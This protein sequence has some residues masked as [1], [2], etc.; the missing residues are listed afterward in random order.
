M[1]LVWISLAVV[2]VT[3]SGCTQVAR[4]GKV[5]SKGAVVMPFDLEQT[6]HMFEK[7]DNG[8]LQQVIADKPDDTEQIT[9]IRQHLSE[10]A[11]RFALGD[12]HDPGMIH[13]EGMPGLH[14]LMTGA[15][16]IHIEYSEIPDG[17]QILYTTDEPELVQAVHAWFDAQLSDHGAHAV[18]HR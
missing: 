9:L 16:N 8:G 6:T 13:G 1:R 11:E 14:E 2:V 10:E 17:G 3:V 5:A 7:L 15:E 18:D 12:F 4:Q